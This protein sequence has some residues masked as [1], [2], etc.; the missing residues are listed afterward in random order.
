MPLLT[1]QQLGILGGPLYTFYK[2]MTAIKL[3]SHLHSIY[4]EYNFVPVFWLAGDDH[5]FEEVKFIKI[6]DEQNKVLSLSYNDNL[7]EDANRGDVGS[8][9]FQETIKSFLEET[10]KK[11]SA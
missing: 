8:I 1:G 4:K 11:K 6:L 10:A 5:D 3:A 7:E 2:I 9:E